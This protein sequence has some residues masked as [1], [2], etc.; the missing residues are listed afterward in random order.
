M[1][2]AAKHVADRRGFRGERLSD[3][4][5]LKDLIRERPFNLKGVGGGYGF[6]LKKIF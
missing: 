5:Y 3:H 6:F 2:M 1:D 4:W